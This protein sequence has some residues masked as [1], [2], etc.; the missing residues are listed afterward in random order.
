MDLNDRVRTQC[1]NRGVNA[2]ALAREVREMTLDDVG[3]NVPWY[4][5]QLEMNGVVLSVLVKNGKIENVRKIDPVAANADR[6]VPPLTEHAKKRMKERGISL[7]DIAEAW[8]HKRSKGAK[9]V[10]PRATIVVGTNRGKG[11]T[12]VTVY[13]TDTDQH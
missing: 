5:V 11:E 6:P 13:R 7:A 10:G 2:D 4:K 8:T 1:K 12:I 9:H 3:S